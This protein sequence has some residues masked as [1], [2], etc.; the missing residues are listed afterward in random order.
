MSW[1]QH[2]PPKQASSSLAA[3]LQAP[4]QKMNTM[5]MPHNGWQMV[6]DFKKQLLFLREIITSINLQG[7]PHRVDHPVRRGHDS[8]P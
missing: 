6:V 3:S 7:R 2:G 4:P 1:R 5:F 8:S